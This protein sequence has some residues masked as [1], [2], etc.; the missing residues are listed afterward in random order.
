MRIPGSSLSKTGSRRSENAQGVTKDN[1]TESV[2]PASAG[3][4]DSVAMGNQSALVAQALQTDSVGRNERVSELKSALESGSYQ[5]DAAE[6]SRAL[7]A[8]A[9]T[10]HDG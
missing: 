8:D 2:A 10:T 6:V 3:S 7:I 5:A 9:L 4:E 1:R